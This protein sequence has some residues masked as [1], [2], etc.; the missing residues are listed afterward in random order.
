MLNEAANKFDN[1]KDL[2]EFY[3]KACKLTHSSFMRHLVF[4][5]CPPYED[6]NQ[7]FYQMVLQGKKVLLD[8]KKLSDITFPNLP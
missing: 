4:K 8:A 7:G 5:Y 1:K 6:T 3:E 2:R